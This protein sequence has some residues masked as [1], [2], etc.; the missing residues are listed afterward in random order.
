M[1]LALTT[2]IAPH[3]PPRG[4]RWLDASQAA[5]RMGIDEGHVRRLCREEWAAAGLA[6]QRRPESGG[7]S[8][9]H[10]RE[11]AHSLLSRAPAA[12]HIPFDLGQLP[13]ENRR[14]LHR[15][16]DI[17]SAWLAAL[18]SPSPGLRTERA[19]TADYLA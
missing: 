16:R 6:L 12:E 1:S 10:V 8:C 2:S 3:P 13:E 7:K 5:S 17:L 4:V 11:D 15:R 18:D 19:I 9:W 14:E